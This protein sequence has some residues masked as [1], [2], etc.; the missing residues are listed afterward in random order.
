MVCPCSVPAC[1]SSSFLIPTRPSKRKKQYSYSAVGDRNRYPCATQPS[2]LTIIGRADATRYRDIVME[3][4]RAATKESHQALVC[5]WQKDNHAR[6][7][8]IRRGA[9]SC[10]TIVCIMSPRVPQKSKTG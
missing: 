10:A 1:S 3:A 7:F 4:R 8:T 9:P 2:E 5:C 6:L